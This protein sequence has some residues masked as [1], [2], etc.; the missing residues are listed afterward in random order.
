M[1]LT[2]ISATNRPNS[3][4]RKVASHIQSQLTT[5][6]DSTSK[7]EI[8]DLIELPPELFLPQSYAE[9][10]KSFDRFKDT[11]LNTDAM[12]TVIPE[13]NGG[14]PGIL[15]YFVDMLPFPQ[16]LQKKPSAFI[17][18]AAG[19]FGAVRAVEHMMQ[20][21]AYRNAHIFSERVFLMGVGDSLS[22][23][24]EPKDELTRKLLHS[25]LTGFVE[26][27]KRFKS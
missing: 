23:K 16:S 17:G 2:V 7:V 25:E 5:M 13:Y 12:I 1:H 4:T 21:W 11:I 22:E 6:L 10:P 9:K 3:T 24:G 20:V 26:F 27:A 8:L 15:K 18:V 19:R 14:A